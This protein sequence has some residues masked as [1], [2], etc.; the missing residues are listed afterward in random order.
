MINVKRQQKSLLISEQTRALM[1]QPDKKNVF[2]KQCFY[3]KQPSRIL[4]LLHCLEL[5]L[6]D[7]SALESFEIF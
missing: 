7:Y 6:L 2:L 5:E 4:F 1:T 3:I